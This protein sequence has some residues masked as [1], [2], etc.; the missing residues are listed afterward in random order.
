MYLDPR[1]CTLAALMFHLHCILLR[2]HTDIGICCVVLCVN[3]R[4]SLSHYLSQWP[5][6][7]E[8]LVDGD[9]MLRALQ[10]LLHAAQGL[11]ELHG[12][13]VVHGDLVRGWLQLLLIVAVDHG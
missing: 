3:D 8:A 9:S 11:Q 12:Q 13:N 2:Q 7:V 5:P 4:G 1:W 10:L 6:P